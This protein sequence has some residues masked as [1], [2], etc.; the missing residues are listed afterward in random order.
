MQK[1]RQRNRNKTNYPI[2]DG[3]FAQF[4]SNRPLFHRL[5]VVISNIIKKKEEKKTKFHTFGIYEISRS[6]RC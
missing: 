2:Q 4:W 3:K 5:I 1:I 6:E